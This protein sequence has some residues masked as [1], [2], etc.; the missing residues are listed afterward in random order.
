MKRAGVL[1]TVIFAIAAIALAFFLKSFGIYL[2]S[3]WAVL[4]IATIGLN[5]TLGYA[6][7]VSLAQGAFVGIGAYVMALL[8]QV[9]VPFVLAF[10]C[11]GILCFAIGWLLGYP[12][13]RVQH[14]YLAFVT[15]AFNT[16]VFLVLRNEEW[17]TG[18]VYGIN[19]I[20]RPVLLG[21]KTGKPLDLRKNGSA[22]AAIAK[23]TVKSTPARFIPCAPRP[24]RAG[25]AGAPGS[26]SRGRSAERRRGTARRYRP[27]TG[28]R[29]HRG[30]G[31]RQSHRAPD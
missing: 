9:G 10:L 14:H 17:L 23:M 26:R 21:W 5:L 4:T 25:L 12:A 29:A 7:Q 19:A 30:S 6:G 20:P 22:I 13:L 31:R 11:A 18:G 3:M 1:L 2:I 8:L 16:L 15:L 28:C 24:G 27:P